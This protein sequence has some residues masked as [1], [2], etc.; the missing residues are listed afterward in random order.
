[1]SAYNSAYNPAG[2]LTNIYGWPVPENPYA[3][4]YSGLPA[5]QYMPHHWTPDPNQVS[6]AP[7]ISQEISLGWCCPSG[8]PAN[9][10]NPHMY[11]RGYST[12]PPNR[13]YLPSVH[14]YTYPV[15]TATPASL[16]H[17]D[18]YPSP[19]LPFSTQVPPSLRQ[20]RVK[21]Y[22]QQCNEVL[23]FLHLSPT[24]FTRHARTLLVNLG[25][26]NTFTTLEV[27]VD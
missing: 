17:I 1:M 5:D 26:P 9:G 8:F 2:Y 18:N 10:N 20:Q 24:E 11:S 12:A 4:F 19:C 3:P 6:Y 22:V 7:S 13:A 25:Y 27:W 15:S 14:Y 21:V 16:E 23:Q